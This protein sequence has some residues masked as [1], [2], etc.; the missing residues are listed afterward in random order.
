MSSSPATP[1]TR[2]T[3]FSSGKPTARHVDP[4]GPE[5]S[6]IETRIPAR[7][8]TSVCRL[9]SRS[10]PST[11]RAHKANRSRRLYATMTSRDWSLLASGPRAK[12]QPKKDSP[13]SGSTLLIISPDKEETTIS[14]PGPFAPP[15]P[16]AEARRSDGS[17]PFEQ[18]KTSRSCPSRAPSTAPLRRH[19]SRSDPSFPGSSSKMTPRESVVGSPRA[20]ARRP[21]TSTG[22][23][24]APAPATLVDATTSPFRST[25]SIDDSETE[26]THWS[27]STTH[28]RNARSSPATFEAWCPHIAAHVRPS[29]A[30]T[31][32]RQLAQERIVPTSAW[33]NRGTHLI[34]MTSRAPAARGLIKEFTGGAFCPPGRR[35]CTAH[36][37]PSA[38]DAP[39]GFL[40]RCS[41]M[42]LHSSIV[43][44]IASRIA[45]C[46]AR[47]GSPARLAESCN[48]WTRSRVVSTT[49]G[50]ASRRPGRRCASRASRGA[51]CSRSGSPR[52]AGRR[53]RL[54]GSR[55]ASR[56][57]PP[58]APSDR[59]G[60]ARR[61]RS[62]AD[63]V[64]E[65]L[66][67][68]AHERGGLPLVLVTDNGGP[69][70]R[71]ATPRMGREPCRRTSAEVCGH[72]GFP[73]QALRA[74]R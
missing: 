38:E 15:D 6:A 43:L 62:A 72:H 8:G 41:R 56:R 25:K 23:A 45:R 9:H 21:S 35:H 55:S 5:G 60:R 3:Q 39:G 66:T 67:R 12:D 73:K 29:N 42:R 33:R 46:R 19:T 27:P 10:G 71:T 65:Q 48:A 4:P 1:F 36:E 18:S 61:R 24:R 63:E 31:G 59:R 14:S 26:T 20:N 34:C 30:P 2:S 64:I 52:R 74:Q 32:R 17:R 69:Y 49:S 54:R 50:R 57:R 40:P 28:R 47:S 44:G 11:S 58:R 7:H 16:G 68:I 37:T 53:A 13:S 51:G 70:G 22:I